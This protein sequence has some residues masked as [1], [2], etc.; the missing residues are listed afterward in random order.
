M[1]GSGPLTGDFSDTGA[2]LG[3]D[4]QMP[5]APAYGV[6]LVIAQSSQPITIAAGPTTEQGMVSIPIP[7][8]MMGPNGRL[9]L[10]AT[11]STPNANANAKTFL[12]R[13]GSAPGIVGSGS[14]FN[15]LSASTLQSTGMA[16][17]GNRGSESS[18]IGHAATFTA[19]ASAV[20]TMAIN[21][22]VITYMNITSTCTAGL[23]A[24]TLESYM[25][26]LIPGA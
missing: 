26:E 14:V 16:T 15:S 12:Y 9:R 21:T 4:Q 23:D 6:P 2:L 8:G 5:G 18:Q 1:A 22:R 17:V 7:A 13:L 24:V 10:T 20:V 19:S 3:I 11:F 25:L